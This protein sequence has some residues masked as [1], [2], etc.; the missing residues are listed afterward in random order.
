MFESL[1]QRRNIYCSPIQPKFFFFAP[2]AEHGHAIGEFVAFGADVGGDVSEREFVLNAAVDRV[3][4]LDDLQ[5]LDLAAGFYPAFLF[6]VSRPTANTID[7]VRR[8]TAHLDGVAGL[9]F[10]FGHAECVIER[11]QFGGVVGPQGVVQAEPQLR[12]FAGSIHHDARAGIAGI[13]FTCAIAVNADIELLTAMGAAAFAD[14]CAGFLPA[15]AFGQN[16]CVAAASKGLLCFGTGRE[17]FKA[18]PGILVH[19]LLSGRPIRE[20]AGLPS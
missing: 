18:R 3:T 12:E 14:R 16:A 2:R 6:P 7:R 9:D 5:V 10:C 8:V 19:G 20:Y 13:G 4:L 11:V 15:R 17:R 1:E